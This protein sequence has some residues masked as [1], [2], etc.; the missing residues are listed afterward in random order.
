MGL[1]LP[2]CSRFT[3][4][5]QMERAYYKQLKQVKK[6]KEKRRK[7]QAQK[8]RTDSMPP[9]KN[10]PPPLQPQVVQPMPDGQ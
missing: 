8:Q 10:Q 2:S 9:P 1:C 3:K 5:G 4:S 6:D 7:Q